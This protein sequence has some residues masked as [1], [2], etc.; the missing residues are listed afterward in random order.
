MESF[1]VWEYS[2]NFASAKATPA[3]QARALYDYARQTDEEVSF[4]EN[5][6]LD[7]Y[8]T[9]DPDWTLVGYAGEYGFA[10]SN[11]IEFPG[12]AANNVVAAYSSPPLQAYDSYTSPVASP[13]PS[14]AA[15]LAGLIHQKTGAQRALPTAQYTPEGSEEGQTAPSLPQRPGMMSPP[16]TAPR[17]PEPLGVMASRG[18]GDDAPGSPGG[19][20]LYKVHEMVSH[21][22]RKKK[23][24]TTLGLNLS[25]GIVMIAPEKSKDGPG[26]QWTADKL[27]NYSIEGKHV[28]IELIRPSKSID[29]HAGNK[30]TAE[31]IT[32]ALGE[33]A[34]AARAEGLREVIAA[35]NGTGQKRGLMLYEFMAQG[36]DEVTVAVGD[37][38][39]VLDDT[40]SDEWWMVKRLKNGKQGV[41]PSSYV[42]ITGAAT[43]ST[44][45]DNSGR[46]IV[47]QNRMDE[48]RITKESASRSSKQERSAEKRRESRS[49]SGASKTSTCRMTCIR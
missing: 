2:A 17:S 8:D 28:F 32:R 36:E 7:V 39:I 19:F 41:V 42:E 27:S 3:S 21:M 48:E 18:F 20:H 35:S 46:S 22:G 31:E 30:D 10:P 26:V 24:P 11:Y 5:A 12:V 15:T 40:A 45:H 44:G 13:E 25:Q 34:G 47:E 14:A 16:I 38:V 4:T 1:R 23:L 29:F 37:E 33:L 6:Q 49:A 9:T 43:R